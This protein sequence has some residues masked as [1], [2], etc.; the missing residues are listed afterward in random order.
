[1]PKTKQFDETEV[2]IKARKIFSQKGYNGTSM[3][4]LVQ[5]T[6]LSRSSIYDTF[7]DKHGLFLKSLNQYRH[8][9]QTSMEKQTAKTTCP[10]KKI[11]AI[12]DY[13]VKDILAD[14]EGKGCLLINVS[15]EL[16]SVD[17]EVI[18]IFHANMD[19][20]EQLLT[21]LI[22]EGQAN[23]EISKRFTP[24]AMARLLYNSLMGL[25]VTGTNKPDADML[26]DVVRLTL[27]ILDE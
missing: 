12:F 15:L 11:R 17:N 19:E 16:S 18:N 26:R 10:K 13:F 4:D 21:S 7:G 20:M 24:K 5:A 1:M 25:R 22:R 8:E 23:G 9:Q 27:S 2:L 3:D 14:K 6:G